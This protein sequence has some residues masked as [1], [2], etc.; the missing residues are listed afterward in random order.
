MPFF[1]VYIMFREQKPSSFA[2]SWCLLDP[3]ASA[4]W[5]RLLLV[6]T[7]PNDGLRSNGFVDISWS[8]F[9]WLRFK[10]KFT[11]ALLFERFSTHFCRFF[12][13]TFSFLMLNVLVI[14]KLYMETTLHLETNLKIPTWI[15]MQT[16]AS[17]ECRSRAFVAS[18][19]SMF[20]YLI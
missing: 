12:F 17:I 9:N 16:F 1:V 2:C 8:N 14:S 4:L 19:K 11:V 7:L 18:E 6:R 15:G 20:I 5:T 13:L 3:D 10:N